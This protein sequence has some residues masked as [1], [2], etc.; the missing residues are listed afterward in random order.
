MIPE[1]TT[2]IVDALYAANSPETLQILV[3]K[4]LN[5]TDPDETL[6]NRLLTGL[7]VLEQEPIPVRFLGRSGDIGTFI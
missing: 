6:V 7:V 3:E 2:I 1:D 5:S 4:I